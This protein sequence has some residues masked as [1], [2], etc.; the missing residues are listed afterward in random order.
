ME[1]DWRVIEENS[2]NKSEEHSLISHCLDFKYPT[3]FGI[4][5]RGPSL[6]AI[7]YRLMPLALSFKH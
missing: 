2:Q 4:R 1:G 6:P 7:G 5:P 3:P